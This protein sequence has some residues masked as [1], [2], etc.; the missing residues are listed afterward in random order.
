MMRGVRNFAKNLGIINQKY[1]NFAT[2]LG[3]TEDMVPVSNP[4]R[5]HPD[6]Q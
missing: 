2:N 5:S 3:I 4:E 1:R 6:L